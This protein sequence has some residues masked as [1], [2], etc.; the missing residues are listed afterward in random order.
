[1]ALRN[2]KS[3]DAP[4]V[5]RHLPIPS[6]GFVNGPSFDLT[7][8]YIVSWITEYLWYSVPQYLS[9]VF[10]LLFSLLFMPPY[11][12]FVNFLAGERTRCSRTLSKS[13]RSLFKRALFFTL[14]VAWERESISRAILLAHFP[15]SSPLIVIFFPL[16]RE[17]GRHCQWE[18]VILIFNFFFN[19]GPFVFTSSTSERE[20][21]RRDTAG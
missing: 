7:P 17:H 19:S 11:L 14:Y 12:N 4:L 3:C 18:I 10:F 13:G 20:F 21:G 1:M 15:P 5:L 6:V 9:W 16:A 2:T 8:P